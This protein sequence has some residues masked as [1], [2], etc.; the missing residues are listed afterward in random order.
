[1]TEESAVVN[2]ILAALRNACVMAIEMGVEY[3]IVICGRVIL[4]R[5][6]D[7]AVSMDHGPRNAH[8]NDR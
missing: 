8:G 6:V 2:V 3:Q 4:V 7:G 1:M 5:I